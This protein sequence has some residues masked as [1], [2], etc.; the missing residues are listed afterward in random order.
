MREELDVVCRSSSS[1]GRIASI[2]S[3]TSCD[4]GETGGGGG[5]GGCFMIYDL[6]EDISLIRGRVE[7]IWRRRRRRRRGSRYIAPS[8]SSKPHHHH[9]GEC[10]EKAV[11]GEVGDRWG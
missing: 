8:L 10:D 1:S 5:G 11:V 7:D 6:R 3:M 2:E 9:G 4:G